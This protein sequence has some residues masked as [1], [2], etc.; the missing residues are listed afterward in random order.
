MASFYWPS[1]Q[2]RAAE[3]APSV[4]AVFSSISVNLFLDAIGLM[5][6]RFR[7]EAVD[8]S[9]WDE[10]EAAVSLAI[11]QLLASIPSVGASFIDE[12]DRANGAL[13]NGWAE[14]G[15]FILDGLGTLVIINEWAIPPGGSR[16]G[17]VYETAEF[18][19]DLEIQFTAIVGV[20]D[21][22]SLGIR[23][24]DAGLTTVTGYLIDLTNS[25][26]VR[27]QRIESSTSFPV[28]AS[29]TIPGLESGDSVRVTAIG[30]VITVFA[31]ISG[32]ESEYLS[33]DD[34][35]PTIQAGEIGMIVAS[36]GVAM[37]RIEAAAL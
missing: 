35:T 23:L 1:V 10:I 36:D 2:E 32:T 15:D 5:T 14:D 19:P 9:E 4:A 34:P 22:F 25:G 37:D 11:D 20:M 13:G 27:L 26:T 12:F 31:T 18:G 6:D 33:Y 24:Q 8:D 16:A 7:W 21:G 17:A 3:D 30:S 28:I 29:D